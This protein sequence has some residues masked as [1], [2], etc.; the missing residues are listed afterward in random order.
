MSRPPLHDAAAATTIPLMDPPPSALPTFFV[1]PLLY[2]RHCYRLTR[3]NSRVDRVLV[4]SERLVCYVCAPDG[5][6]TWSFHPQSLKSVHI[7]PGNQQ[8]LFTFQRHTTD[9]LLMLDDKVSSDR[10]NPP[11]AT[12]PYLVYLLQRGVPEL[13]VYEET[14]WSVLRR[15]LLNKKKEAKGLPG[16]LERLMDGVVALANIVRTEA[17]HLAEER[18]RCLMQSL[19][20]RRDDSGGSAEAVPEFIPLAPE[21]QQLLSAM[22]RHS[23]AALR[24]DSDPL[25]ITTPPPQFELTGSQQQVGEVSF[26]ALPPS[27]A[28][29]SRN[30]AQVP[31]SPPPPTTKTAM[32]T[33]TNDTNLCRW[34]DE[35]IVPLLLRFSSMSGETTGSLD[36]VEVSESDVLALLPWHS[37]AHTMQQSLPVL[38]EVWTVGRRPTI[39][40][41]DRRGERAGS[42]PSFLLLVDG[43]Y[44]ALADS[45]PSG[46]RP[47]LSVKG[48]QECMQYLCD[49]ADIAELRVRVPHDHDALYFARL[50]SIPTASNDKT[51]N[52]SAF[53]SPPDEE[54]EHQQQIRYCCMEVEWSWRVH[55]RPARGAVTSQPPRS[56]LNASIARLRWD[57]VVQHE[58]SLQRQQQ[59]EAPP[60]VQTV[61]LLFPSLDD[62]IVLRSRLEALHGYG[63]TPPPSAAGGTSGS[64][65]HFEPT[66]DNNKNTQFQKLP[67]SSSSFQVVEWP[68]RKVCRRRREAGQEHLEAT[69]HRLER[70]KQPHQSHQLQ[71]PTE[72]WWSDDEDEETSPF[73]AARDAVQGEKNGDDPKT[74]VS[75]FGA[76][77]QHRVLSPPHD[78]RGALGAAALEAEVPAA[79]R[80]FRDLVTPS[81]SA[82]S[83]TP[84]RSSL[85]RQEAALQKFVV[86]ICEQH[87]GQRGNPLPATGGAPSSTP[88]S[89]A[90]CSTP[91][92][93]PPSLRTVNVVSANGGSDRRRSDLL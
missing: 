72:L 88:S 36:E 5:R 25:S 48:L 81:T 89:K 71:V 54:D 83:P 49:A 52:N 41:D 86:L 33:S 44:L 30:P 91:A 1:S 85:S 58:C 78:H 66:A 28:S 42:Q 4:M 43:R 37:A 2:Y 23:T 92:P 27:F 15:S 20:R 7:F 90:W 47:V 76:P 61:A 10:I 19:S 21:P 75:L 50:F 14:D 69:L 87:K 82:A 32:R 16:F 65:V 80:K 26:V 46:R 64:T 6:A 68:S 53:A 79:R 3:Q 93:P 84:A 62:A 38:T 67:S 45:P 24:R 22:N 35:L 59:E 55:N 31:L 60:S 12:L 17:N 34:K 73:V 70:R 13:P 11:N 40:Q 18:Q 9:L 29:E 57:A 77:W 56:W 8:L 74:M 63:I 39:N 51:T